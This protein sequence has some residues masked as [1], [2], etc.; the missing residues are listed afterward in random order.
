MFQHYGCNSTGNLDQSA[1]P[2]R[3]ACGLSIT[4][5]SRS[6]PLESLDGVIRFFVVFS[7]LHKKL[8]PALRGDLD[9]P[10]HP[11]QG[12]GGKRRILLV[13][14]HHYPFKELRSL[15]KDCVNTSA[16]V[17]TDAALV[18]HF[19]TSAPPTPIATITTPSFFATASRCWMC[20][21]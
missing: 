14:N 19:V 11:P 1:S 10:L 6:F 2:S 8:C 15:L 3:F 9:L 7:N 12:G 16:V 17:C 5:T 13:C 4:I 20:S 21:I 18:K